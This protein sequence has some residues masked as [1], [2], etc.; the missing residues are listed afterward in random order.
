MPD[1]EDARLARLIDTANGLSDDAAYVCAQDYFSTVLMNKPILLAPQN[2]RQERIFTE[3]LDAGLVH[4]DVER[5]VFGYRSTYHGRDVA[6]LCRRAMSPPK[7]EG[8]SDD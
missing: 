1:P 7:P 8:G 6:A 3:L 5:G 4:G 2:K